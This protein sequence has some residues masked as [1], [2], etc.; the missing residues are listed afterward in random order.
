MSLTNFIPAIWSA[1]LLANLDKA[2][3]Y[4]NLVDRSYEGEVRFGNTLKLNRPDSITVGN[5]TGTVTYQTPTSTPRTLTIDQ[6]RYFAFKVDDISRVQANVDLVDT[7]SQRA[8]YALADS[9]DQ[10]IASLYPAAGAGIATLDITTTTPKVYEAFVELGQLLDEKNVPR[11]ERWVVVSPKVYAALLKDQNF[12]RSTETGQQMILTGAVGQ[13]AGFSVF[14]SNNVPVVTGATTQHKCLA[15]VN[16]AI[17]FAGNVQEVE[18]IRLPNEFATGVRGL[19]VF[20][21][22]V[23]EPDALAVLDVRAA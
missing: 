2:L 21:A 20:G 22:S 18:S 5:Y 9:V 1:R 19:Y 16:M 3:V 13:V 10:Y 8:A 14:V 11:Q 12:V 4:G 17:V 15:G 7:Y 23:V 6:Q